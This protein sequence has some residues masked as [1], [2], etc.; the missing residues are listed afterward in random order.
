MTT[1]SKTITINPNLKKDLVSLFNLIQKSDGIIITG[2]INPDGDNIGSQLALGEYLDSIGKKFIIVDDDPVPVHLRFLP[3]HNLMQKTDNVIIED[4]EYDLMIAV[5]SGD[6]DRIGKVS[7]FVKDNITLVNIDHHLE[8]TNFGD[9]NII[10]EKACSIGEIL[11]Y[12]FKINDIEISYDMAIDIYVSIITDTGSFKYDR[13]HPAV[14]LIACDLMEIGVVPS[15]FTI[16]LYQSRRICYI[17]LLT[18]SLSRLELYCENRIALSYIFI[19][20][21]E[22]MNDTD[23]DGIIENMGII[24]T[25]SVYFLIKEKEPGL[26]SASLRSKFDVDVAKIA[27][28]FGGGG[29]MRA[30]GC[31]TNQ[32]TFDEFKNRLIE[33]ISKQL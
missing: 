16:F 10:D 31:K 8:N 17:K 6:I 32:L 3:N 11:Y 20:D 27:S 9:I 2:H 30:A 33:L 24:D 21:F 25:V 5:D 22:E 13:M 12:F 29:H 4:G 19:E 23:T 1:I 14:H 15:E 26:Y 7:E 28:Y 18:L